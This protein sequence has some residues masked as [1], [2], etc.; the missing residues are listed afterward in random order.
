MI[1]ITYS[2]HPSHVLEQQSY[3]LIMY[4]SITSFYSRKTPQYEVLVRY[5]ISFVAFALL[6]SSDLSSFVMDFDPFA[7]SSLEAFAH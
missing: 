3:F 4:D 7:S 2:F 5:I 1:N 6:S